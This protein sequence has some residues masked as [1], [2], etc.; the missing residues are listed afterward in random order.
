VPSI[1]F[2]WTPSSGA[3]S[4][5]LI[6]DDGQHK[7]VTQATSTSDTNVVIGGPAHSY[8]V[9]A[10]DGTG[11]T[12][13][14][15]V[16]VAPPA[17]QCSPPPGP[18][19]ITG[20]ALCYPGDPSHAMGPAEQLDWPFS[21]YANSYDI[22][23]NG[24][25]YHAITGSADSYSLIGYAAPDGPTN[26]YY[27]VA[28]NAAGTTTSN[29]VTF[30]IPA[31]I[32]VTEPPVAVLSGNAQCDAQTHQPAV[33][34]SWT[35][36]PAAFGWRLYRDGTPYVMPH[37]LHYVDANVVP[38]HTYTYN[39]ATYGLSAPLSNP[40][41]ITVS[42]DV[43]TPGPIVV[44]PQLLCDNNAS[45]VSLSWTPSTNAASY[46]VMRDATTLISGISAA[47]FFFLYYDR[48]AQ[49]GAT[50][51]YR[52]IG[53]NGSGSTSSSP[54]T[55]AVNDE[56]C[57]PAM[58]NTTAVAACV[59]NAPAVSLSWSAS[60]H[61]ASYVI[62]RDRAVIS[63]ALPATTRT[64]VDDGASNGYHDYSIRASNAQSYQ[65]SLASATVSTAPCGFVPE[66]FAASVRGTCNQ[67]RPAV[68]LEWSIAS[69][70]S[71]YVI[72]RNGVALPGE[73]T[74][75]PGVFIDAGVT[76]GQPYTYTVVATNANGETSESTG[77]ITPSAAD[78]PPGGF[79]MF[80]STGCNPP[81]TLA[82]SASS[83]V[84]NYLI[85]REQV[86]IG[87][88]GSSTFTYADSTAIAGASYSYFVRASGT[89]GVTDSNVADVT[90]DRNVCSAPAPNLTAIGIKPSASGG[91]AGDTISVTVELANV[92]N[93]A[94]MPS[95]ARIR[96]GRGPSMSASDPVLATMVLPVIA[97]GAEMQRVMSVKLPAVAAGTYYLFLSLDEEHAAG[98]SNAGDNMKASAAFILGEMI[99]P[100]HRAAGH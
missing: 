95:T 93:A 25:F 38:G 14:N 31:D 72:K 28:K 91:R 61:A 71:S 69:G 26:S 100:K 75:A 19:T 99:P 80:A 81:V 6:R 79:S 98:E 32:C 88:V 89:G 48:S 35:V 64:F 34:L 58:F 90:I 87:A 45:V 67:G 15:R 8:F 40:I 30:P 70:A 3:T 85:F 43:C 54:A 52:V 44:T 22:Y 92:G 94:A 7:I 49:P 76:A 41:T 21:R 84:L 65:D 13:S 50:Y 60:L 86:L 56:V 4:Y 36:V 77:T 9:R 33:A 18:F 42:G 5:D 66:A 17:T 59:H 68:R 96:F 16:T 12:D 97:S 24:S 55:I 39:I 10:T 27:V 62:S 37:G 47:D 51:A 63:A 46:T 74:F 11:T 57:P 83:S 1:Y 29:T 78:C 73:H 2:G 20:K 23:R 53:V 82:W